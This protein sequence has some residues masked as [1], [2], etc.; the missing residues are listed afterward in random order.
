[1]RASRNGRKSDSSAPAKRLST[2][3]A[4]GYSAKSRWGQK[5]GRFATAQRPFRWLAQVRRLVMRDLQRDCASEKCMTYELSVVREGQRDCIRAP[6]LPDRNVRH[7]GDGPS[8][9]D[10]DAC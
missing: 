4:K 7:Q 2:P 5:D 10:V 1:M 3:S 8:E 6:D 9:V